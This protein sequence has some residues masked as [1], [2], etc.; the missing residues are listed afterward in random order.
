MRY[1]ILL[2]DLD[3]TLL[4]FDANE[5]D[6]LKKLF[7]MQGFE[8]T[9]ELLHTYHQ[10]NNRL[11]ADYEKGRIT[12]ETILNT[13]FAETMSRFGVQADGTAWEKKYRELLGEGH[14]IIPGADRLC[15][16]LSKTHRLF[17]VTNGVT[18]TQLS[19]LNLSG[20]YDYFEDVFTSQEIGIQKPERRFFDYV[21]S[22]IKDFDPSKALVIGDS[23]CTDMKGGAGAGLDTCLVDLKGKGC[24][25]EA[26]CTYVVTGLDQLFEICG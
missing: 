14:Q 21:M 9:E 22:H 13:R 17:A 5:A 11:W 3:G 10:I 25:E 20:L 2:F 15:E 12:Q 26:L 4:D 16:Q 7:S 18:D 8:L 6:S 19:R 24:P 1:Q 23:V